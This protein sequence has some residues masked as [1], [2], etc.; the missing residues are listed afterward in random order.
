MSHRV[1]PLGI[2]GMGALGQALERFV[3][4]KKFQRPGAI[5]FCVKAFDL[6]QALIEQFN[7]WPENIPFVI[8]SNGFIWPIVEKLSPQL[9]PRPIRIGMTTIGS[10]IE[11]D[12][13]VKIF[14]ENTITA[15]GNWGSS[16]QSP[17]S[18]Q[19]EELETLKSFPNASWCDDIRPMIQQKWILN[20]VINTLGGAYRLP[21][22]SLVANYKKEAEQLLSEAWQLSRVLFQNF[23]QNPSLEEMRS[24]LWKLV[25]ATGGNENSMA[26]D[27][28]LGRKTE[29]DFL[30]GIALAHDGYPTLKRLHSKVLEQSLTKPMH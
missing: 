15:W 23:S 16:P 14:S 25:K 28:R 6:E 17:H 5:L 2:V 26:K 27:V 4:A 30:A 9:G 8:L 3:A 20:V 7:L 29:S 11:P 19:S 21:S 18:P 22:N 1:S 13:S 12:G 10:T 24:R